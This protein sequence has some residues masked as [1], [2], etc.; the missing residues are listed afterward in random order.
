[1]ISS[2]SSSSPSP[3]TKKLSAKNIIVGGGSKKKEEDDKKGKKRDGDDDDDKEE[4]KEDD[5]GAVGVDVDDAI[6]NNEETVQMTLENLKL[7]REEE[8]KR[9]RAEIFGNEGD[10]GEGEREKVLSLDENDL[11]KKK[12]SEDDAGEGKN[13]QDEEETKKEASDTTTTTSTTTNDNNNYNNNNNNNINNTK[14]ISRN[15]HADKNDPDFTRRGGGGGRGRGRGGRG[16][17]EEACIRWIPLCSASISV[18]NATN[19]VSKCS[20]WIRSAELYVS[21]GRRSLQC[22]GI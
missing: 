15:M 13:M 4:E 21:R 12:V 17:E 5:A 11:S 22:G 10:E 19:A 20:L 6:E 8:Y 7:A 18:P 14:A 16:G 3:S 9:A 1:M 2:T